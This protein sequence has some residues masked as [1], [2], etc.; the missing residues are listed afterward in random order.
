MSR[1]SNLRDK[2][3]NKGENVTSSRSGSNDDSSIFLIRS[4]ASGSKF[5]WLLP[6]K[7]NNVKG[8]FK[9]FFW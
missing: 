6:D 9:L 2:S 5:Y 7:E 8:Y 1:P 3:S 4:V